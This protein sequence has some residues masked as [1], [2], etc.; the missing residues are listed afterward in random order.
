L[1][2]NFRCVWGHLGGF[3]PSAHPSLQ[4]K[5]AQL[6]TDQLSVIYVYSKGF[7]ILL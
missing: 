6:M 5:N 7:S 2:V 1:L 4:N 3:S